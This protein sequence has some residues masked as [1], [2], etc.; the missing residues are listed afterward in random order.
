MK[1]FLALTCLSCCFCDDNAVNQY[2]E[3]FKK[4]NQMESDI[5]YLNRFQEAAIKKQKEYDKAEREKYM[6]ILKTILSISFLAGGSIYF[7]IFM[8]KLWSPVPRKSVQL[9][10][11]KD[12]L[13]D[14]DNISSLP[15]VSPSKSRKIIKKPYEV[16]K[17]KKEYPQIEKLLDP[18]QVMKLIM[19]TKNHLSSS[20]PGP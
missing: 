2:E 9:S 20:P 4:I 10:N 1:I 13:T 18:D 11:P 12:S 6:K 5:L 14:V 15:P 17:D 8:K 19:Q 7:Y 16:I 3:N